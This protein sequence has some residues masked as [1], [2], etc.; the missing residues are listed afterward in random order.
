MVLGLP[1]P[2]DA[3]LRPEPA[4]ARPLQADPQ[5]II[6]TGTRLPRPNE[7]NPS[8][9][10]VVPRQDFDLAPVPNVEQ[11]LNQLPQL[12]GGFTT[13]SNNPGTGAATLDLRG[14]GSVRTL[15]LVNG[16]RWIASD[17]GQVP[18]VD[19]NTI[20]AALIER[21][22]IVTG[23]AS[24][25]YGADAVTGVVN[26]ILREDFKGLALDARQSITGRGDGRVSTTDLTFGTRALDGRL[27]VLGSLGWLD[28]RPVLQGDRAFSAV[29]LNDGCAVPGTR[30]SNGASQPVNDPSCAPPNEIALIASGS[31]IIPGSHL[32]APA[33]FPVPGSDRLVRNAQGLRFEP[34]GTP[35]PYVGATDAYNFAPSNYLQV[36]FERLSAIVLGSFEASPGAEFYTELAY[37]RT[38]SAQQ[39]APVAA[40][41]GGGAGTVPVARINLANPFLTTAAARVLELSYGIDAGGRRG[42]VG[43]IASGFRVNPAFTGDAD[44]IV[45]LVPPIGTRPDLGPR[46]VRHERDA[47][48]L[49]AGVRGD[50]VDGWTY[51]LYATHS[52]VDHL[53]A[54]AN[55]GSAS[56]LQQALLAVREPGTGA[57]SCLD[58]SGGCVPA[59][60]FGEGNLSAAAADFIRTEPRDLTT[61]EEQIAE[62]SLRGQLSLFAAGP[63]G[64]AAG[65]NW[66]RTSYVFRPDPS[67]FT[68]DILG[69]QPGT[70]A[71]GETR[72]WELFA[73][74]RI[75]LLRDLP[76]AQALTLELGARWSHHDPAGSDWTWKALGDW[77]PVRGLRIR[78]GYQRA[79][80]APNVRELFEAPSTTV[81]GTGDPCTIAQTGFDDP[82]IVQACI[83]NGV[84][85]DLVGQELFSLPLISRRGNPQVEPEVADTFTLG[86]V[87]TLPGEPAISLSL[88]YYDIRIAGAIGP[89]GGG[90]DFVVFACIIG[91]ADPADPLCQAFDRAPEGGIV[92]VDAPTANQGLLVARG[93]DWQV[94]A[95]LDLGTDRAG[96]GHRLDLRLAGTRY[97]KNGFR[98]SEEVPFVSCAGRFGGACG[99]TIG[100]TATPVWKLFNN[101]TWTAGAGS[102]NLR[103]R[104]FSGTTDY[105]DGFRAAF[106]LPPARLPD[107]GRVLEARHYVDISASFGF[108]ARQRL[109]VGVANLFEEGPPVTGLLQVQANTDPSLYDVLGRRIFV[110]LSVTLP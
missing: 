11:L 43:S 101:L 31:S 62:A 27:K 42:F 63:V 52:R 82:A 80:R 100:G 3:Q 51:D 15:I 13:T 78:G 73:E 4:A 20:P 37:V 81:G 30:R 6:V 19:V 108:G 35:R 10:Q 45:A 2:A 50:L 83:R 48:R 47:L 9:T 8:P 74:T 66:R 67:L 24:A 92:S 86:A 23:G 5:T 64:V 87:L 84:P 96:R 98:L 79:V 70:P 71:A 72:L 54:Y 56:R 91:G 7:E 85:A 34:D 49:L 16:R 33:F 41:L 110:S 59:N 99:N 68:G 53:A 22:D 89:F 32:F 39:L 93:I 103:H 107:E 95:R 65:V 106:S 76:L 104:W 75:P 94:D 77:Q 90:G 58:P 46:Q 12:V 44:G 97:L 28:Q 88:D 57:I 29:T 55:G 109:T 18:E 102:L 60:I 21:V 61:V 36:P 105:R 38:T 25:V 40:V 26:F 69:F 14:L 1:A 17:A